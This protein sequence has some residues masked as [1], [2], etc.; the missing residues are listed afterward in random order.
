MLTP[1]AYLPRSL[2][3]TFVLRL[4]YLILRGASRL[5][6]FSVYPFRTWLLRHIM[7]NYSKPTYYRQSLLSVIYRLK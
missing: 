4:G 3:G 6:A 1:Q 5:D 7:Y 2:Q